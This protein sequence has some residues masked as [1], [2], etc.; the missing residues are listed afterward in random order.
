MEKTVKDGEGVGK[1]PQRAKKARAAAC[2]EV[3]LPLAA[4]VEAG[5]GESVAGVA[6]DSAGLLERVVAEAG[7]SAAAPASG[8]VAG[9]AAAAVVT[10]IVGVLPSAE[11]GALAQLTV[12]EAGGLS[13]LGYLLRVMRDERE[14][15]ARRM[16]AAK[17]AAPFLHPK[18]ATM[19][20][21]SAGLDRV[22]SALLELIERAQGEGGGVGGL[23]GRDEV[24]EE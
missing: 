9:E 3:A 18:L 8:G 22:G 10:E 17:T 2:A 5:L 11:E 13:P 6:A 19:D 15:P 7:V 20:V 23:L 24:A 12:A 14:S 21:K 4:G 16:D 1:A